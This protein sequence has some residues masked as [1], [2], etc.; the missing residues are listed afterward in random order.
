MSHRASSWLAE[1]PASELTGA[2]F[3]V[4][5]HLCD[6][7]NSKR[8][9]ETACFPSQ[10][11][12]R[13]AAGLSNGG[14]NNALNRLEAA[15]FIKRIR[16][17]VP[18]TPV[19]RVYYILG[20]DLDSET[21]QTPLSGDRQTPLSGGANSTFEGGKLH[22]TGVTYEPVKNREKEQARET[23]SDAEFDAPSPS[24][25]NT[26]SGAREKPGF[27]PPALG[28]V[29]PALRELADWINSGRFVPTS[30]VTNTKR[31]ALLAAGLV[32]RERLR[33]L[34]IY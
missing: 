22:Y 30:S 27:K 25:P 23:G 18:G 5:F 19:P 9:P 14:L 8:D 11:R 7:H 1:I 3:R 12:L 34:Q 6:A 21:L 33:E 32:T 4:L 28:H 10:E 29:T 13:E 17:T 31:D 24:Q 16:R 26:K 2:E 15:G 20:F